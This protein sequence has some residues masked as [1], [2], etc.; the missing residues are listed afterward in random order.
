MECA[1][2]AA[3]SPANSEKILNWNREPWSKRLDWSL[4]TYYTNFKKKLELARKAG[5]IDALRVSPGGTDVS[6]FLA[7][8]HALEKKLETAIN[9]LPDENAAEL[10]EE[11]RKAIESSE[12]EIPTVDGPVRGDYGGH[13]IQEQD[14]LRVIAR[15]KWNVRKSAEESLSMVIALPGRTSDGDGEA[16]QGLRVIIRVVNSAGGT[17]YMDRRAITSGWAL[18]LLDSNG[19]DV[20]PN[21]NGRAVKK[22]REVS[23][24]LRA[25]PITPKYSPRFE[26]D[27]ANYFDLTS[28][29]RYTIHAAWTLEVHDVVLPAEHLDEALKH[30]ITLKA[31]PLELIAPASK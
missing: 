12:Q 19:V 25:A 24:S 27:L 1:P 15:E 7:A 29:A 9:N 5:G 26:L 2:P 23:F 31:L 11:I 17:F 10:L 4:K 16:A 18:R 30:R 22:F 28:G 14:R 13:S 3:E 20:P 8:R 21:E 6:F